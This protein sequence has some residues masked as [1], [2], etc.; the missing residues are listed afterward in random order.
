V[1]DGSLEG[2]NVNPIETMVS[3]IAASRQF[4]TQMKLMQTAESDEKAASQLLSAG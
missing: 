4:E 1:Q 2:S 3:M